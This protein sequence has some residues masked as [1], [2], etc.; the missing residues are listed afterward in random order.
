MSRE[1]ERQLDRETRRRALPVPR[2]TIRKWSNRGNSEHSPRFSSLSLGGM[3][4]LSLS[5]S[6]APPATVSNSQQQPVNQHHSAPIS[7]KQQQPATTSNT[8]QHPA[9]SALPACL[10]Q[11]CGLRW[12]PHLSVSPRPQLALLHRLLA[13][14][15]PQL[16]LQLR[17]LAERACADSE[18]IATV[19]C[20]CQCVVSSAASAQCYKGVIT[21]SAS[22]PWKPDPI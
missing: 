13:L 11:A 15:H 7:T 21:S 10:C 9:Q 12:M 19:K 6:V 2:P 1:T 18:I 5:T 3:Q 17:G 8:Q 22:R 14:R 4:R 16:G 20:H